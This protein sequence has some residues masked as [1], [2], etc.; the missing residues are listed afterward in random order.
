MPINIKNREAEQLLNRLSKKKGVG[1]S[2]LVLELLRREASL[3]AR[4]AGSNERKKRIDAIS[5]RVA[6]RIA[7]DAPSPEDVIGYDEHGLAK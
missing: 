5:R 6:K 7:R 1:K 2:Q 4:L 3:Q